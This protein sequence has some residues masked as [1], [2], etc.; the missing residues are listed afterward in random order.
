M[1]WLRDTGL[2][3]SSVFRH[4]GSDRIEQVASANR[5][6]EVCVES[7]LACTSQL[8]LEIVRRQHQNRQILFH[9]SLE[10]LSHL[11]AVHPWHPAIK[12]HQ[13]VWNA[14]GSSPL[15]VLE[16]GQSVLGFINLGAAT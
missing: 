5:F 12:H 14:G 6:H 2:R 13:L 15:D 11:K 16:A 1:R 7:K 3:T 10:P 8:D 4:R 9:P